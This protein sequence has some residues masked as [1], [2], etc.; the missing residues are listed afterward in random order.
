MTTPAARP[1]QRE[2][3]FTFE[4]D[5]TRAEARARANE[6]DA[7]GEAASLIRH[8]TALQYAE[9]HDEAMVVFQDVLGRGDAAFDGYAH[10]AWQHMGKC[11]VELGQLPEALAA[12]HGAMAQRVLLGDAGL[13]A[14]TRRALDAASGLSMVRVGVGALIIRDGRVL[15]ARRRGAHGDGSWSTP[16]GHLEFGE[17]PADCALRETLEETGVEVENARLVATT[18]DVLVNDGRH[19]VTLWMR[20]DHVS[21]AGEPIAAHE[22]DEVT[23]FALDTLPSPLFQPF[24]AMVASGALSD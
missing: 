10:F 17:T 19:Y 8:A 6:G 11:L 22:L 9:R 1:F 24:D 18:N 4:V 7:R 12:F 21:G 15:M 13:I 16:G 3:E 23:W 2:P 14:S 20:C 5:A